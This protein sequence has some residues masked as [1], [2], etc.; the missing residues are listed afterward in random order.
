[1]KLQE[2]LV[3]QFKD[4]KGWCNPLL[5]QSI[6]PFAE[7]HRKAGVNKPIA[8][9]GVFHGKFFI[10]LMKTVDA[11]VGHHAIDV[12]S[13]Q[14]FNLDAAGV[15]N[16]AKFKEN[17]QLCGEA[18]SA[19]T[20]MERDS[21]TLTDR[22]ILDI[23][24]RTGGFSMFSVDGC[25]QVEHTI[26]D[27]R[28]AMR[29]TIPEGLIFVDD[30]YNSSWP[31]VQEGIAKLYHTDT[32]TFVPLAYTCNKLFLCHISF[33][34]AYLAYLKEYL[35]KHFKDTRVTGVKRYGYSTV[36]VMPNSK[37]VEYLPAEQ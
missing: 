29:L 16:L 31:G 22:D 33:H 25:H 3:G 9:I 1:M 11:T 34:D 32:P 23:R 24:E 18:H 17:I 7:I 2:Y 26:I 15:G 4:V 35:A 8:E 10:G 12:F 19:V 36:N 5:W 30:Y 37:S 13:M 28:T 21:L 14:Q 27:T 6:Y 20:F